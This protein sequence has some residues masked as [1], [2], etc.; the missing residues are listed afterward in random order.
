MNWGSFDT[1]MAFQEYVW[2]DN[3]LSE[4]RVHPRQQMFAKLCLKPPSGLMYR[5]DIQD[6]GITMFV[7]NAIP[8]YEMLMVYRDGRVETIKLDLRRPR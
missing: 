3:N 6:P 4:I 8:E 5:D 7:N 1:L 2:S